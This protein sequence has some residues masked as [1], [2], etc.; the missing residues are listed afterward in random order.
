MIEE[1][2]AS[3]YADFFGLRDFY[4]LI[5]MLSTKRDITAQVLDDAVRRNFDGVDGCVGLKQRCDVFHK[6]TSLQ[7][8]SALAAETVRGAS[9]LEL[10][11]A[12][13]VERGVAR[14]A[15]TPFL[16]APRSVRRPLLNAA[17]QIPGHAIAAARALKSGLWATAGGKGEA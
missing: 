11:H 1:Q 7:D 16:F 4:T 13:L 5:K 17:G 15:P 12:S 2:Q 8:A 10:I 6:H 14:P 3:N 9:P